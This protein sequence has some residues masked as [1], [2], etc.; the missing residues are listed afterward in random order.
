[1]R[2]HAPTPIPRMTNTPITTPAATAPLLTPPDSFF[3]GAELV[4]GGPDEVEVLGG[5]GMSSRQLGQNRL[6]NFR[7]KPDFVEVAELEVAVSSSGV[8]SSPDM[9]MAV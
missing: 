8:N 3:S 4:G 1:M 7:D 9:Y 2:S 5:S 6:C